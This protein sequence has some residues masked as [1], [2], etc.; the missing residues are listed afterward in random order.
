MPEMPVN[1]SNS[2][3]EKMVGERVPRYR[4]VTDIIRTRIIHGDYALKAVPSDRQL[5]EELGVNFMTVRR[6]LQLL[7]QEN[8]IVREAN[9]KVRVG[10][11]QT[12]RKKHLNLAF[13]VPS[14]ESQNLKAWRF[15]LERATSDMACSIR[16]VLYMHWDDPML[17]DSLKGFDGVFLAPLS[18]KLTSAALERLR[19]PEHPLVVID[20]DYSAYGIPSIRLFPPVFIHR[21]LDHLEA[22]GHRRIGCLNT[23]PE[24]S[25]TL[26]RINQWKIWGAAHGCPGTLV[27]RPV[28]PLGG[29]TSLRAREV[30]AETLRKPRKETAWFCTTMPAA[31]GAM[32]AMLD[33]GIKPGKEI[34]VCAANGED[35]AAL[36]NPPLTTLDMPDPVPFLRIAVEWILKGGSAWEGSLLLEPSSV[37]LVVRAST[38]PSQD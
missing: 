6:G 17:A 9:G 2:R 24:N 30:M 33:A 11:V 26:T 20:H 3:G 23:E 19:R 12:G 34:A 22:L 28:P 1:Q 21:L 18:E 16:P 31:L 13:V 4:Q 37:P 10:R 27:H 36:L 35:I 25:E 14:L 38:D 15:A 32:R 7:E 5:A 29:S 8:L